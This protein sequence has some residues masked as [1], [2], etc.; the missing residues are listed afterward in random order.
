MKKENRLIDKLKNR[1]KLIIYNDS[2]LREVTSL[3][4]SRLNV[5]AFFGLFIILI[6]VAVSL[7]FVFTPLNGFLPAYTDSKLKREMVMNALRV[8][9]IEQVLLERE[10]YFKNISNVLQGKE[11]ETDVM[12]ESDTSVV[13]RAQIDFTKTKHDSLLRVLIEEEE[14]TNLAVV[15][16]TEIKS[17]FKNLHFFMPVKGMISSKFDASI[18]HY[19]IDLVGAVDAPV[20]ATLR[21]TVV[22]A[23]WS[24]ATGYVIQ[25]QHE[26]N[27]ISIYKHNSVLLKKVGDHVEAG[28]SIAII[29]NTGENTTGPHLHFEL[30]HNGTPINPQDYIAF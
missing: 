10:I 28:E 9:S 21:G 23:Q 13:N 17:T 5:F 24:L 11:F 15:N 22:L 18:A 12:L 27:L 7:L 2:T 6:T 3:S 26:E 14:Q 4:L 30:W 19:G 8:D 29:G 16:K 1:Y 25:I 20:M